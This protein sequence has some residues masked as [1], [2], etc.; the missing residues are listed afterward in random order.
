VAGTRQS[1]IFGFEATCN[2]S[3]TWVLSLRAVA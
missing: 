2:Q 3:T 1:S